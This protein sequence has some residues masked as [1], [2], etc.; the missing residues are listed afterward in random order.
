MNHLFVHEWSLISGISFE[1]VHALAYKFAL[2]HL[3]P[4][5]NLPVVCLGPVNTP[6]GGQI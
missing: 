2:G 6:S 1:W 3:K 5:A 4:A